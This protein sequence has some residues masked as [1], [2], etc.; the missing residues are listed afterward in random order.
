MGKKEPLY[1]HV[2]KSR[3]GAFICGQCGD[4]FHST[5]ELNTHLKEEHPEAFAS[6]PQEDI[7]VERS[8]GIIVAVGGINTKTPMLPDW[9]ISYV[10]Y[11]PSQ[12][13]KFRDALM[14]AR[15][16]IVRVTKQEFTLSRNNRR[17][18]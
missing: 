1:P 11:P 14:K 7:G 18:R 2:P 6:V 17:R 9:D 5:E 12:M 8:H 10:E 15:V 3:L 4:R 13:A 16:D